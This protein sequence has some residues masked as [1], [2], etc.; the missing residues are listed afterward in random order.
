MAA[1]LIAGAVP[2]ALAG[3]C[4]DVNGFYAVR[5][6][7]GILGATFVPCQFYTTQMYEK[8]VVGS[9][10]AFA[11][12]W[13][14][15]G[16]GLTYI[17][18]PLV[19]DG[20]ESSIQNPSITWRVA[21]V[22]PA[23]LCIIVAILN[24][25]FADDYP[26]GD[27]LKRK[28]SLN[29]V[30]GHT[31]NGHVEDKVA[32]VHEA[33]EKK[34]DNYPVDDDTKSKGNKKLKELWRAFINPNVI[35][36]MMQYACTFGVELAVDG[37]I[38]DFFISQFHLL[39]TG[40]NFIGAIFGLMNIFS[41]ATGGILSDVANRRFGMRG[42]LFC[43]FFALFLEGLFLLVFRFSLDT[44]PSAIVVM[45]FF[46]YFTQAGCGTTYGIAPYVDPEIY[47]TVAGLIGT[48]GTIGGI[49]FASVFKLYAN[50][51]QNGFMVIGLVVMCISFTTF[52]LKVTG[53]RLIP[54]KRLK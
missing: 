26:G 37:V 39:V 7:I 6:F 1:L 42:R 33:N 41:R 44:L 14:N 13:G 53:E 28:D 16:G 3:L 9:A 48:G 19:F 25:I 34:A 43:Q 10:N 21:L 30:N 12:G 54:I 49:A 35:M 32:E 23:G 24:L 22:I 52:L 5:F 17:L 8:N 40:G 38:G 20:L 45:I 46:S 18:M 27:W 29:G 50:S 4:N 31:V 11:G 36:L 2:T 15:L 51:L 47:G